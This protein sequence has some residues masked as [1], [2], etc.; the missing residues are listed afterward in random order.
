MGSQFP[1]FLIAGFCCISSHIAFKLDKQTMRSY[2][3]L[4]CEYE[5]HILTNKKVSAAKDQGKSYMK[6]RSIGKG[7]T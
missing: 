4:T 2:S 6:V 5:F 3:K 1:R 7:V